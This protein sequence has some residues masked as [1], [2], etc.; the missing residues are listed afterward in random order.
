MR[1]HTI[2]CIRNVKI[3]VNSP[4][5]EFNA[6]HSAIDA[7]DAVPVAMA[8]LASGLCFHYS[9]GC[10]LVK[11]AVKKCFLESLK[12]SFASRMGAKSIVFFTKTT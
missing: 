1:N 9:C 3:P 2:R 4:E 6:A 11:K 12:A 8:R 7:C 5:R 10:S